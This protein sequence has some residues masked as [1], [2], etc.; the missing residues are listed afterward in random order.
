MSRRSVE[1]VG[2]IVALIYIYIYLSR[3]S[4]IVA[5]TFYNKCICMFS[6]TKGKRTKQ[7]K[8]RGKEDT[9]KKGTRVEMKSNRV[10]YKLLRVATPTKI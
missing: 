2:V 6:R 5:H 9:R 4:T 7:K 10:S 3:V 1:R 8:I